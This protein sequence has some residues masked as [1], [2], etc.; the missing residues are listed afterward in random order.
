MGCWGAVA[1][2]A[3]C[4][5][6]VPDPTSVPLP[7]CSALGRV[8]TTLPSDAI[9]VAPSPAHL[10]ASTRDV[11][12]WVSPRAGGEAQRVDR[13]VTGVDSGGSWTAHFTGAFTV[14]GGHAYLVYESSGGRGL[15]QPRAIQAVPHGT[16]E[17]TS[18]DLAHDPHPLD[19]SVRFVTPVALRA[20]RDRDG[21]LWWPG[22]DFERAAFWD[23][24]TRHSVW[25]DTT[26]RGFADAENLH[27]WTG[28]T[29]V[30]ARL[31]GAPATTATVSGEA[32]D[33]AAAAF[34]SPSEVA[35][36]ADS[37][38]VTAFQITPVKE[39]VFFRAPKGTASFVRIGSSPYSDAKAYAADRGVLYTSTLTGLSA[40]AD[41]KETAICT[42]S[43]NALSL[44]DGELF[45]AIGR[46]IVAW[47]P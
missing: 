20:P 11:M 14:D 17:G 8:V 29:V 38:Y 46:Q 24:L 45:V 22:G 32:A 47:R 41:G 12:L 30:T 44:R 25:L 43:V 37:V 31:D 40:F 35:L 26:A 6:V 21:F 34:S 33:L 15:R 16:I 7:R 1:V 18:F 9:V 23:P 3:G 2:I 36:D 5:G 10:Y 28:P 13:D 42:G 27:V 19:P 4:G 39:R